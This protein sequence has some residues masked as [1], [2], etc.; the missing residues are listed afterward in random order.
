MGTFSG[1]SEYHH[2]P[3]LAPEF[4]QNFAVVRWTITFKDRA[5]GW[6]TDGVHQRF[7]EPMIHAAVREHLFCPIYVLMP[8]HLHFIWMGLGLTSDQRNAMKFL[9]KHLAERVRTVGKDIELQKQSHDSVLRE[10]NRR[11]GA[12]EKSCFYLLDN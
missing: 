7:R 8:D 6:L 10:Q 12:F 5:T 9:R 4:Y 2:L 1:M 11:R 3:R